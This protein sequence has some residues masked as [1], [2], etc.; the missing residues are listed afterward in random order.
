MSWIIHADAIISQTR[1]HSSRMLTT[2]RY[3]MGGPWQRS[4]WTETPLDRDSPL[5]LDRDPPLT[6]TETHPSGQRPTLPG[7][8]PLWTETP[9][10]EQI[11][12]RRK[13]ITSRNFVAF[14]RIEFYRIYRIY[15]ICRK[16]FLVVLKMKWNFSNFENEITKNGLPQ[17]LQIL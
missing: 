7:Q 4:P 6:W 15:R 14:F 16:L 3:C 11:T 10:C 2:H 12:D 13:N 5:D 17:I 9:L 1:M 8:R